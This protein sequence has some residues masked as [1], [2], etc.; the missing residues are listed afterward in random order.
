MYEVIMAR[1]PD[2]HPPSLIHTS[3]P[4]DVRL[5]LDSHLCERNGKVLRG[6]YSDWITKMVNKEFPKPRE[7]MVA[8][9]LAIKESKK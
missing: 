2:A 5:R 9:I 8:K 7:E 4:E 6:A 1:P 3:I